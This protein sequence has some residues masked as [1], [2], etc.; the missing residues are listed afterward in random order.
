MKVFSIL[1]IILFPFLFFTSTFA[2]TIVST[3]ISS[4]TTWTVANS[5]YIVQGSISVEP[6]TTLTIEPGVVV[7]MEFAV[8]N[9]SGTLIAKGTEQ[10][11]IVFTS[12][13]DDTYGG[14]SNADGDATEPYPGEWLTLSFRASSGNSV[15]EY[16][17]F[18]YGG[19]YA[20]IGAVDLVSPIRSLEFCQF[21]DCSTAL[22]INTS[23]PL[24]LMHLSFNNNEI[25][26]V[27]IE[28]LNSIKNS[29][30]LNNHRGFM[31]DGSGGGF[32]NFSEGN[33]DATLNWW[34]IEDYVL[35]NDNDTS[36]LQS[37]YDQL[38]DS[39]LG[40]VLY[41]PM[42][43][44]PLS[45]ER[46]SP[47]I[48]AIIL[49][50][51]N[52]EVLGYY[53]VSGAEVSLVKEDVWLRPD[54]ILSVDS[55]RIN[56]HF[57][58]ENVET[59]I[60]DLV[61]LNPGSSD[62]LRLPSAFSLL[63]IETIPFNKWMPFEVSSGTSFASAIAVPDT[64]ENLFILLKKS[65]RIQYSSTW[66]GSLS[67]TREGDTYTIND[68]T[69]SFA[70]GG[71]SADLDFNPL[72]PKGGFYTFEVKTTNE[73]GAGEILFTDSLPQLNPGEWTTGE[74]LRPYG[75]DWKAVEIPAG[76]SQLNIRTEGFGRWS[77][78][79]I[80]LD[81]IDSPT[82]KWLFNNYGHG[83]H[84]EGSI[85]NPPAGTY[86]I[87]Y[88]DSA[89]ILS[90]SPS[91]YTPQNQTR[92]YLIV[93]DVEPILSTNPLP[94]SVS[95]SSTKEVGQSIASFKIYGSGFSNT[96]SIYLSQNGSILTPLQKKY[97]E[98]ENYWFVTF[99]FADTPT[100]EW[101]V[102]V[103]N[104]SITSDS[105]DLINVLAPQSIDI[106]VKVITSNII[107]EGRWRPFIVELSNVSNIDAH[108]TF[109]NIRLSGDVEIRDDLDIRSNSVFTNSEDI[110]WG[111]YGDEWN[112][113]E[114]VPITYQT[115]DS[116]SGESYLNLPVVFPYIR[117]G[118][119]VRLELNVR[120]IGTEEFK[121]EVSL[122]G[123]LAAPEAE[124]FDDFIRSN[125]TLSNCLATVLN[126]F[127]DELV[128]QL[129]DATGITGCA[130]SIAK[131]YSST[132]TKLALK[133]PNKAIPASAVFVDF[134][135]A[136]ASCTIAVGVASIPAARAIKALQG[137]IKVMSIANNAQKIVDDC[138]P[139]PKTRSGSGNVVGSTTPEDKYGIIGAEK[140]EAIPLNERQNF[141]NATKAFEYRIDYWNKE[142]ASAPA[143]E[144]FIRDTL[145]ENLDLTTFNFT[146]IGFLKWRVP[147]EGGH[148]FN[149][150]V[151]MRPEGNYLVQVTGT[152]NPFT[153]EIYWIH[154][155]LDPATLA[156]PADPFAGYLP[157]IDVEGFNIGW[158]KF[159]VQA[160]EGLP[161]GTI[162]QNQ[163][164]VNFDGIG[165]WGPA[166]PYG[167]YTNTYDFD[168]PESAVLS[169][170]DQISDST[171]QVSWSGNDA[172]GVGIEYFDIFVSEDNQAYELWQFRT[173]ELSAIYQG[174]SGKTYRF[175][176]I[177][178]DKVGNVETVPVE[179][180]AE[181]S[182]ITS[183]QDLVDSNPYY[184]YQN[185]PNPC[186]DRTTFKFSLP[187]SMHVQF[188]IIDLNG[189]VVAN[190]LNQNLSTGDKKVEWLI[191]DHLPIGI[192][193]YRL[194][195]PQ[196]SKVLKMAI[197]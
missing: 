160:K 185:H 124:D 1:L 3:S 84:I 108:L 30:F 92:E 49:P 17:L 55:I 73:Q 14:D 78:I 71:G 197:W 60:Y 118:E 138:G 88:M 53:F 195:T 139:V 70:Y 61:V 131:A 66:A 109:L 170:I 145:D 25:G 173:N 52:L 164:H 41:F 100:G 120:Y 135:N 152:L 27:N 43:S 48:G 141:I 77:S 150:L 103:M 171:L 149:V 81:N 143:A 162:F 169:I 104:S 176:S 97:H 178:V 29:T 94:L 125:E 18:K 11:S 186:T 121:Y 9:I 107:R 157:P 122:I 34:G 64:V 8:M 154:R 172:S 146:E 22:A 86:Y 80:F 31:V 67:F 136:L 57:S 32:V 180:D 74:I 144:V 19:S 182:I 38:D 148:Y 147:L 187:A 99:N 83:Y 37:I 153:R 196:Y 65:T 16:C 10:D 119:T 76:Q 110:D 151:D 167:P 98:L 4:N 36:N 79:E 45:I 85:E 2:Q 87:R 82:R 111:F 192:Y 130:N 102:S 184:L 137:V 174:S 89:V 101:I 33:V 128:N 44:P 105:P 68:N 75:F 35:G 106:D 26:L 20:E 127:A 114:D 140:S 69:N 13:S 129:V 132:L 165:P 12:I 51:Q 179:A 96:D 142:N 159:S 62:T 156:L 112:S 183:A 158:V 15:L 155:T 193:F 117:A 72:D 90:E 59:G 56:V 190:I 63:D 5:P 54:S 113:W 189:R 50:G 134:I 188:D 123:S 40:K 163:A 58:W 7:K 161:S 181:T 115:V 116:S 175:Y 47:Q 126:I 177:A 95:G 133:E 23:T 46:V 168:A 28:G 194:K 39:T 21:T 6:N 93:V 166:P 24:N 191:P 91:P 42:S